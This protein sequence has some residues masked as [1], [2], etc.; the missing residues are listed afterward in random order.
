MPKLLDIRVVPA[1]GAA[2]IILC[3]CMTSAAGQGQVKQATPCDDISKID[4]RNG[5]LDLGG[6]GLLAFKEGRACGNEE[7]GVHQDRNCECESGK[8]GWDM[9]VTDDI[10]LRPEPNTRLRLLIVSETHLTGSGAWARLMLFECQDGRLT[11]TWDREYLYGATLTQSANGFDVE[12]WYWLP[13]E[14]RC[15]PTRKQRESFHWN[16]IQHTYVPSR[17]V[18]L[19]PDAQTH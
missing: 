17:R 4:F 16:S 7:I 10:K 19:K 13:H 1:P 15:C 5:S 9:K 18:V 11:T 2:V 3:F 14:A 12:S 8:C 6:F